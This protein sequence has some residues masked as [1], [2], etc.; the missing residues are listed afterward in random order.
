MI[1]IRP[2]L[3]SELDRIAEIDR[4]EEVHWTYVLRNGEL[5]LAENPRSIPAWSQE[6][7]GGLGINGRIKKWRPWLERGG[8]MFGAFEKDRLAGFAI[9]RPDLSPG[10]SQLAMLQVNRA[11]RRKGIGA[12][13]VQRVIEQARADGASTLY[14]SSAPT[15]RTVEFYQSLGFQLAK[16]VNQELVRLEPNDIQLTRGI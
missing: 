7:D 15:Q 3:I 5:T 6:G 9:Y 13:L 11:H 2:I 10:T 12:N 1:T 4:S 16:V 8:S 14:V